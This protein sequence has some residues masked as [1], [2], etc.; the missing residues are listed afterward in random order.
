M[1][2]TRSETVFEPVR[3][4]IEAINPLFS[5][6]TIRLPFIRT[7]YGQTIR[8]LATAGLMGWGLSTCKTPQLDVDRPVFSTD[9]TGDR[10]IL[11]LVLTYNI[12]LA[13]DQLYLYQA[14]PAPSSVDAVAWDAEKA[15]QA[16]HQRAFSFFA[17]I[18]PRAYRTQLKYLSIQQLDTDD[19]VFA[20]MGR[21]KNNSLAPFKLALMPNIRQYVDSIPAFKAP[22]YHSNTLGYSIPVYTAI[23]E[24]GHYLTWT[25]KQASGVNAQGVAFKPGSIVD[26][27][28]TRYWK[29][30]LTDDLLTN[31]FPQYG[32]LYFCFPP[33]SFV[34]SYAST[35]PEEDA[36]ESF[37]Q[38]VLLDARPTG[39]TEAERKILLFYQSPIFVEVRAAI[40]ANLKQLDIAPRSPNWHL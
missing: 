39:T 27:L 10:N 34:G 5:M 6:T 22:T 33:G 21:Q 28:I 20:A 13:T 3:E 16:E 18:I 40:R 32:K 14:Y 30:H 2:A 35:S 23:H 1:D 36:A 15:N 7:F 25:D 29:P 9:T 26:S 38:F 4:N 17:S 12:D 31:C 37:A 11:N 19:L 8:V 24:F